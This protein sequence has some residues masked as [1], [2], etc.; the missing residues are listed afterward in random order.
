[1]RDEAVAGWRVEADAK[2]RVLRLENHRTLRESLLL[3]LAC[4]GGA[5][6]AW[7]AV[8]PPDLPSCPL[9]TACVLSLLL[10][11]LVY[12]RAVVATVCDPS[13]HDVL[14]VWAGTS[15]GVA[16]MCEAVCWSAKLPPAPP[17]QGVPRS[18][19][20]VDWVCKLAH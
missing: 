14:C 20:R 13:T 18:R 1:M 4:S 7:S 17:Q 10:F 9:C 15:P 5:A 11:W 6:P 16:T 2:G 8:Q 19:G 12:Q 3:Q